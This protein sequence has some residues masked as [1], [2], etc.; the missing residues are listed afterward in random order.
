MTA[1]KPDEPEP[2]E[3]AC[4]GGPSAAHVDACC[5]RD[6]EAKD[7][8]EEGCGCGDEPVSREQETEGSTSCCR[9]EA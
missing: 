7:R 3:A 9:D 6:A 1:E 5:V 8:G 4:C 2:R